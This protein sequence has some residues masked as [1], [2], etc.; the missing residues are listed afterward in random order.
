MRQLYLF[1]LVFFLYF[2]LEISAHPM[3]YSVLLLDVKGNGISAELQFPLKEFQF[4]FPNEDIDNDY[5]TLIKR[6]NKWL[7]NY[8]L[9]HMSIT[10]TIGNKWNITIKGKSVT[11]REFYTIFNDRRK[12]VFSLNKIKGP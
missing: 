1:I 4:V 5:K 12:K 2:S 9:R 11:E 6:Q 8:L 3:P 10:D 7:D